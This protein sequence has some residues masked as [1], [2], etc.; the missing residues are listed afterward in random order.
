MIPLGIDYNALDSLPK[1]YCTRKIFVDM[2]RS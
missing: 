2:D 1:N